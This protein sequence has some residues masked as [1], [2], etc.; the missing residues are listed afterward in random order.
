MLVIMAQ[1][2]YCFL[3]W[4][5]VW[6]LFIFVGPIL[7]KINHLLSFF[8]GEGTTYLIDSSFPSPVF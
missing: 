1:T 3:M 8:K 4:H 2:C 7:G 5:R 6:Q